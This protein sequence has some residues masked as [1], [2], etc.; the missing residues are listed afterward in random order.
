MKRILLF[1]M[2]LTATLNIQAAVD[3]NFYI[4]LC[5]GQ[6]NMEGQ[7]EPQTVDKAYVDP[8]F[9][10]L[11]CVDFQ[12]TSPKRT[13]GQWYTAYCPLVRDWT[14]IGMADYFGRTMVAALPSNVKIGVVDVAIGGVD[15]KGFMSEEVENYLANLDA[16]NQ[17]LIPAF[18]AYANDPYK[19]LVDM[20]KIAQQSGVIKGIL[21]HQGETNT[22]QTAWLQKVKTVYERLLKDLGLNAADVPLFAGEVVN[23]DVGGVCAGHNP[24]I[25][26]LPDVIPTAHVIP[27]NGC[28]CANDK[29]HFTIDGY[30]TM[31]KRYAYEALRLMG[32]ATQVQAGYNWNN[33]ALQKVYQLTGLNKIDDITLRVGGS[34]MLTVWG[35]FADGHQ[36]NLTH[37]VTFTSNDFTIENSKVIANTAKKGKVTASYTDFL[38]KKHTLDINVESS[39]QGPNQ[40][41]VIGC[42]AA[43]S[44][45][46]DREAICHLNSSMVIGKTYVV[47]ATIRGDHNGEVFL[48]PRWG[49][50]PNRDQW[51][52]SAD[53][54]YLD[55]KNATT[56]F[57]ELTWSF[58]PKF[59]HDELIFA[60]GK[61]G[62]GN[63]YFDD[64]S[65]K[66]QSGTVEM[67]PNG[68][69]NSDDISNWEILS[70]AGMTKSV[71]EDNTSGIAAISIDGMS[72]NGYIYNLQGMRVAT[73]S[74][75]DNL[76]HG[77]Y[78]INGKKRIKE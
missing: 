76:P 27:S 53:V 57:Q 45:Q 6:S 59:T 10:M 8:R 9:Q 63:V 77:I 21:L 52:N 48:W 49:A 39:D 54:E 2:V 22:G 17:Y 64:V 60:I 51:Q 42:G 61:M 26:Q 74:Q 34:K 71:Q 3:P 24:I 12:Y 23:A 65:C 13:M 44:N 68:S 30:R 38:G 18:Q 41:L 20:A 1:L 19:R 11:A 55:S 70:W 37:E 36:E 58:V 15:I 46:W 4:Y 32:K 73:L 31:G 7:A 72:T 62:G 33:D 75:W 35:T 25:A 50:S 43:S 14:K 29:V 66:E 67:V 47:R 28:P 56:T 40:V 69:F 16:N 78:L 5:F